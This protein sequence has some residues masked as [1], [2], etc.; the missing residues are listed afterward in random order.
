MARPK[1]KTTPKWAMAGHGIFLV[2]EA[3]FI[4]RSTKKPIKQLLTSFWA[5]F[6]SRFWAF[7]NPN[8][9]SSKT[10]T[11]PLWFFVFVLYII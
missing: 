7:L 6:L 4:Y 11:N 2:T 9:G 8:K 10:R 1:T 3:A 5:W